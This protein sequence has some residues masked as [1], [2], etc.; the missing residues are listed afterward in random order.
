[1]TTG[2]L[3]VLETFIFIVVIFGIYAGT[4][5]EDKKPVKH[6][7]HTHASPLT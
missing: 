2:A 5:R 7:K 3:I 4:H 6:N 1:M